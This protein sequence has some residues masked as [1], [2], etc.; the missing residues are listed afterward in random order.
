MVPCGGQSQPP[1]YGSFR[2]SLWAAENE[3]PQVWWLKKTEMSS[4]T[5][6]EARSP[7]LSSRQD[8]LLLEALREAHLESSGLAGCSASRNLRLQLALA[9]PR[10][11][12]HLL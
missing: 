4:L 11:C 7:K 1:W 8:W 9:S 12:L 3:S 6:L 10:L 5:A 2:Q